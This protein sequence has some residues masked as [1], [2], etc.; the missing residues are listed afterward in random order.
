MK[1]W[2]TFK[3]YNVP[4]QVGENEYRTINSLAKTEGRHFLGNAL[5]EILDET[6]GVAKGL[7]GKIIA[8]KII[9]KD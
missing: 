1:H 6:L 9:V 7:E 3:N 4:I 2:K 5:E 8:S